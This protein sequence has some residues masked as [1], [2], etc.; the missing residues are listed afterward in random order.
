MGE[1]RPYENTG[2]IVAFAPYFERGL[3]LLCSNFFSGLLYYY[4]IQLHHL[5]P[6]SFVHLSVFVHLCEAFL[7]IEP[8]FDLFRHLFH[9]KSQPNS[10]RLDVV[11]G[12]GIQ[13]KQGMD[14][15]YIPYKLSQKVVDW[16]P[17]WFYVENQGKTLPTIAPGPPII[18][19][20]WLK[21]PLD[22]SQILELLKSIAN[23]G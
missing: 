1:D 21:K 13:L 18:Q 3:G 7:G 11:G 19:V 22:T 12:V 16:K 10:T 9:L 15:V 6:N 2:E 5:T 23:L 17:K 20:E 14:K 4:G 8:H